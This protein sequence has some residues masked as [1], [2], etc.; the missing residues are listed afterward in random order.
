MLCKG[1]LDS[2]LGVILKREV[3][4][5]AGEYFL[6]IVYVHISHVGNRSVS[7][8]LPI[9]NPPGHRLPETTGDVSS[10]PADPTHAPCC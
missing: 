6:H 1:S 7:D 8:Y 2:V 9:L 10:P 4:L 3:C 5:I